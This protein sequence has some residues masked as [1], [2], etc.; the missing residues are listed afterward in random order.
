MCGIAGIFSSGAPPQRE[1]VER[2]VRRLVHRG[3]DSSGFWSKSGY[4]AGMRRLSIVDIAGGDQPLFDET[5]RI[6]LVYNGEI[7]NY[8]SL[9]RELE[10]E[11]ARFQTH[12]DGEVICHLYRK[13]GARV[14]GMLDGM[15]AA[16]LWDDESQTLLLARDF[17]GEKPLYYARLADGSVAFASEIPSLLECEGVPRD[18]DIQALW[19]FPSYLWVPEPATIYRGVRAILPGEGLE[20]SKRGVVPFSFK[21]QIAVPDAPL[22]S[23]LD[24]IAATRRVVEG[25]VRSRLL[26]D[27]PVGAFLSSGL[28]S[29]IVCTLARQ[30]LDSLHT[31]C[32]GFE[33][34]ADP[35]HGEA[36]ESALAESM[37]RR[38]GT[39][40]TTV[41]VTSRD[42]RDLLPTFIRAAG[43]PYAVSSG[44]GILAVA[45]EARNQGIRVLLSG[46]GADEAFGGY[47][48]YPSIPDSFAPQPP[49][50]STEL[51]RF[52]DRDG[53]LAARVA[54]VATYPPRVR[55][56]AW[57]YYASE[58]EKTALFHPDVRAESSLHCFAESTFAEPLD[59]LRH[60]RNFYFHN[61]MLS[62]VDRM[63]MAFSVEGRA[64]F[65]APAVQGLASRMSWEKLIRDG[66]LKWVLRKAFADALPADVVGRP[67]HGFNVPI[68]HWLSDEWRDLFIETFADGSPLVQNGILRRGAGDA[69]QQLL[70]DPRKLA[71]HVLFT[72]VMLHLW[73]ST[74]EH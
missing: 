38:L 9:R 17:P 24:A 51:L 3:P 14:F 28:D 40:H 54:R 20:I 70:A 37:A 61:E 56:W 45:R 30:N 5:G 31:F 60:D 74:L 42:F 16:A 32:V 35:Y 69:A 29:S 59:Y 27:V 23:D 63:T 47:S 48:W 7:Y 43:Q 6:V 22:E 64:P 72:F 65:A 4:Q 11:G 50:S 68:D 46:D 13:H 52:M 2:M 1:T 71:G 10:K 25:A 12:S 73:M 57:H 67:K 21:E 15:F 18:L 26:S 55:A 66:Q 8:P 62:K 41:R 36:D 19:D 34:V 44:L 58:S 33:N 49:Q 39:K 53:P